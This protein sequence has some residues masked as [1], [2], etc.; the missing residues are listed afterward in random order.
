MYVCA[1]DEGKEMYISHCALNRL[2]FAR[3]GRKNAKHTRITLPPVSCQA[4]KHLQGELGYSWGF[5]ILSST[6]RATA[7]RRT[8]KY[9][10]VTYLNLKVHASSLQTAAT[11]HLATEDEGNHT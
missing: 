6:E 5:L 1:D 2:Q 8:C 11:R 7:A 10:A 9:P 3:G 4:V